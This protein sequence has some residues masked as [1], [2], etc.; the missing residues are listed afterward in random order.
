MGRNKSI[1]PITCSNWPGQVMGRVL[2]P[3]CANCH[4]AGGAAQHA[5]FRVTPGDALATQASVALQIDAAHP[6]DS[7]ILRKP[8]ATIPH[9]GGQQLAPGSEPEQILRQWVGLVA[10]GKQCD[11]GAGDGPMVP[12]A[13]HELLV[14]ASMDLRGPINEWVWRLRPA[15][16]CPTSRPRQSC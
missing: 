4:A 16:R 8:L 15:R 13:A 7:R 12:L 9:A 10:A 11:A 14:R 6:D 2:Q 1:A 3:I 5:N